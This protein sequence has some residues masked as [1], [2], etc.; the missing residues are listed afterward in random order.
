MPEKKA[1]T[2]E[3]RRAAA[4]KGVLTRQRR[5]QVIQQCQNEMSTQYALLFPFATWLQHT[6]KLEP[7]VAARVSL[8]KGTKSVFSVAKV[9]TGLVVAFQAGIRHYLHLNKLVGEVKL[10]QALGLPYFFGPTTASDLVKQAQRR[11][12]LEM[13]RLLRAIGLAALAQETDRDIDIVVDTTGHPS[14]SRKR[15][16]VAVGY[17]N[18]KKEPCLKSG[19]VVVNGRP[20]FVQVYPGN[21][22]PDEP[23]DKGLAL[24]RRLCRR[25]PDRIVHLGMDTGFASQAHEQDLQQLA[26]AYANFRYSMTVHVSHPNSNPYKTVAEAKAKAAHRWKRVNTRSR[27]VEMGRQWLYS[28]STERTRVVV[29]ESKNPTSPPPAP[30]KAAKTRRRQKKRKNKKVR[31]PERHYLIATNYRQHELKAKALFTRHHQRPVVEFSIKDGKQSYRIQHLPHEKY[32]AN[33]MFLNLVTLAQLSGILYNQ[34]VL[35]DAVAGSLVATIREDVWRLPGQVIDARHIVLRRVY[36]RLK[37]IEH[38]CQAI[39]RHLGISVG[40]AQLNSS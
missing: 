8:S 18:G 9:V 21:E 4:R 35:P 38:V 22:N 23:F 26:S 12:V 27:V 19:R 39:K 15:E 16:Q 32:W 2:K 11:H 20:V 34:L 7:R 1:W 31:P 6:I 17:C 28:D 40:F 3:K 33:C 25:F 37:I 30:K 5:Q 36:Y 14:D 29:V 24:A 10:A 13:G